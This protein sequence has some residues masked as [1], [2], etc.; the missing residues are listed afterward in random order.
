MVRIPIFHSFGYW[1]R[2]QPS[3]WMWDRLQT[4]G[5]Q[6]KDVTAPIMRFLNWT[7]IYD[8]AL[9]GTSTYWIFVMSA[10]VI[11]SAGYL[12]LM[13]QIW[14]KINKGKMYKDLPYVYPVEEED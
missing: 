5:R 1:Y 3:K 9:K 8:Y 11:V 12:E 13:D 2:S 7:R 4:T 6:G 10:S 14:D